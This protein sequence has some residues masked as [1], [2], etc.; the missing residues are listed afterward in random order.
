[1]LNLGE[2]FMFF[3]TKMTTVCI[4]KVNLKKCG[5]FVASES[6]WVL[7]HEEKDGF[8]EALSNELPALR[9]KVGISQDDLA[10][11]IGVSRQTFGSVERGERQMSWNTYLSLIMFF[12]YNESTHQM[13]RDISAFP[14]D[15]IV[16][17]ND[18]KKD[19]N[20]EFS[21]DNLF[22]NSATEMIMQLDDQALN[23]LKTTLLVE[24]ARCSN[25]STEGIVKAFA[26]I[27]IAKP[28]IDKDL[29]RSLKKIK[30]KNGK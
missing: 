23:T 19:V 15:L 9:A 7:S 25:L 21:L 10:R 30:E 29:K 4:I 14:E 24:Y 3:L 12:D 1:M 8:I 5:D 27:R 6:K 26:G 11:L 16:R 28:E 20:T 17:F 2:N 18:G 13:I 22:D